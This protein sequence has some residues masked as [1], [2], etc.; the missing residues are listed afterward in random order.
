MDFQSA[1]SEPHGWSMGADD[2]FR[3][4]DFEGYSKGAVSLG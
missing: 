1:L 4:T 2:M 3:E